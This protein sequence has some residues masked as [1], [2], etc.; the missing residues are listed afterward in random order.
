MGGPTTAAT[1]SLYVYLLIAMS[2]AI[3]DII[4]GA[5]ILG[6]LIHCVLILTVFMFARKYFSNLVAL[7][8]CMLVAFNGFLV[9]E[10]LAGLETE[11]FA[12]LIIVALHFY[13]KGREKTGFPWFAIPVGMSYY[14]RPEAAIFAGAILLDQ[15]ILIMR[16]RSSGLLRRVVEYCLVFALIILPIV[17][18]NYSVSGWP[19]P[20]SS[21]EKWLFH[22]MQLVPLSEK[23]VKMSDELFR[24]FL[25]YQVPLLLFVI[26]AKPKRQFTRVVI[27]S[28]TGIL[29]LYLFTLAWVGF[30]GR[31]MNFT[32][33]FIAMYASDGF[34]NL[35]EARLRNSVSMKYLRLPKY[36]PAMLFLLLIIGS[37]AVATLDIRK[38]YS[39]DTNWVDNNLRVVALWIREWTPENITIVGH[40]AG[41]IAWECKPRKFI[42]FTG[43][44]QP[45]AMPYVLNDSIFEY[46]VKK[47]PDYL[48]MYKSWDTLAHI[49]SKN[50]EMFE[51]I[52]VAPQTDY[53]LYKIHWDKLHI[54]YAERAELR[55][56]TFNYTSG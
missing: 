53:T 51:Q 10:A 7:L 8:S 1:G 9:R 14:A 45:E 12:I 19:F 50:P 3:G 5:K 44:A 31:Y 37:S 20:S 22:Q 52:L 56:S 21:R 34:Q 25:G 55:E 2:Q 15:I 42:D 26:L 13:V 30:W 40:D 29:T 54:A 11:L 24:Y 4:L 48:V 46:I 43:L 32:I 23:I 27:L 49:L 41:L 28:V 18:Y 16:R 47:R 35:C 39:D 36:G 17:A 33:P 6:I 38:T